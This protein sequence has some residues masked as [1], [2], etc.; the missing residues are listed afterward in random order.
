MSQLEREIAEIPERLTVVAPVDRVAPA[1][2]LAR[3][4]A[5][6][7]GALHHRAAAPMRPLPRPPIALPGIELDRIARSIC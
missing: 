5:T 3:Y 7:A 1:E 4:R 6:T 2:A